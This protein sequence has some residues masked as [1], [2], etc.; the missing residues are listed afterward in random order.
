MSSAVA[1]ANAPGADERREDPGGVPWR[2]W[3]HLSAE[4]IRSELL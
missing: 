2:E 4:W 1:F 3:R